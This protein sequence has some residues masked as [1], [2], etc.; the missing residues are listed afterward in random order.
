V[1]DPA[2]EYLQPYRDAVDEHGGT[3]EAT[4]WRKR[5]GQRRRFDAMCR[6]VDFTSCSVLDIGCGI[7]DFASFL[8]ERGVAY[9]SYRGIDAM[10]PMIDSARERNLPR[11]SYVMGDVVADAALIT[12]GDWISFSG[13]LNAMGQDRAMTIIRRAW[14]AA[15]IGVVFNFLSNRPAPPSDEDLSPA[16]RFDTL[17]LLTMAFDFG[18]RVGFLQDYL[19]CHD[20]TIAISKEGNTSIP[21]RR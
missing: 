15:S 14:E 9:G 6:L 1:S 5:D 7:G 18:G 4:L 16:S 8:L 11:T 19:G 13:T 20:A 12:G 21:G 2:P 17:E 10:G 3:F